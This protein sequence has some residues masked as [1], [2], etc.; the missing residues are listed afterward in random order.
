MKDNLVPISEAAKHLGV[1]PASL[2]R[3]EKEGLIEPAQRTPGGAR[4]YDRTKLS[5][6]FTRGAQAV[7]FKAVRKTVCYA[8]V[9]THEQR[10]DLVRQEDRLRAYC[11]AKGW[12]FEVISDFGSGMNYKKRGLQALLDMLVLGEV[13]RLVITHKDRLLRF[14]AELVFGLCSRLGV[15]VVVMEQTEKPTFEAELVTDMLELITVFSARLYGARSRK[16]RAAVA[17]VRDALQ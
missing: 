12:C 9:S 1:T 13:E 4:R 15:E 7:H 11:A 2:R 5:A 10:D 16:S 6:P 8:R 17:A 14:G 3:W